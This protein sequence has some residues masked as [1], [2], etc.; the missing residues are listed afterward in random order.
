MYVTIYKELKLIS[1]YANRVGLI[2]A[3]SIPRLVAIFSNSSTR[4]YVW[5][6]YAHSPINPH[7]SQ[8]VLYLVGNDIAIYSNCLRGAL[9][10]L[11]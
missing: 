3:S 5:S 4:P 8:G 7:I 6:C 1:K 11:E 9:R 10:Q 2:E